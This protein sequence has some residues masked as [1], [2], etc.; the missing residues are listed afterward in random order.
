[1]VQSLRWGSVSL[2]VRLK[3]AGGGGVAC[4]YMRSPSGGGGGGCGGGGS[5]SSSLGWAAGASASMKESV[6]WVLLRRGARRRRLLGV[7]G[8][9]TWARCDG[10]TMPLSSSASASQGGIWTWD[11]GSMSGMKAG[12]SIP[13]GWGRET[14]L[15]LTG[16]IYSNTV[17]KL[18]LQVLFALRSCSATF[19]CMTLKRSFKLF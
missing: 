3:A 19:D 18:N 4:C 16:F 17:L 13:S 1:M 11:M 10:A 14:E 15:V 5:W 8:S 2:A 12:F 7:H 9:L 6:E